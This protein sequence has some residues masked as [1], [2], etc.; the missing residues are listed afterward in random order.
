M[1]YA[2]LSLLAYIHLCLECVNLMQILKGH[3]LHTAY[4]FGKL[5]CNF[6]TVDIYTFL[7]PPS[8]S[9]IF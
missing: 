9:A 5:P 4:R 2:F 3:L 7:I 6:F 8:L 1:F